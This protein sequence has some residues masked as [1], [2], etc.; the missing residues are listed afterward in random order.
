MKMC[1]QLNMPV[2]FVS[3]RCFSED[4]YNTLYD[5][6]LGGKKLEEIAF[7]LSLLFMVLEPQP[8]GRVK[9]PENLMVCSSRCFI[10]FCP[11]ISSNSQVFLQWK[12]EVRRK[13]VLLFLMG[14]Q[15]SFWIFSTQHVIVKYVY[16]L[17]FCSVSRSTE[18]SSQSQKPWTIFPQLLVPSPKIYNL[19]SFTNCCKL[20]N[21]LSLFSYQNL[22]LFIRKIQTY[23]AFILGLRKAQ[24]W[25]Q[26]GHTN[27]MPYQNN[28]CVLAQ[29]LS[30][31]KD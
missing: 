21:I 7:L 8:L 5:Y 12:T 24:G 14:L 3:G 19:N 28:F 29:S 20:T 11:Q 22:S 15:F 27:A 4:R 25:S 6:P 31:P 30:F 2:L 23:E 18:K 9:G 16:A 13:T 1:K 26:F 10:F 17:L